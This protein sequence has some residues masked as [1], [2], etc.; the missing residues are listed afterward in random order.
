MVH[1]AVGSSFIIFEYNVD[2]VV[3]CP[4]VTFLQQGFGEFLARLA[5]VCVV[6]DAYKYSSV[7]RDIAI[8]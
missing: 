3:V 4:V 6:D 8:Q 2:T 7:H 5:E 1:E